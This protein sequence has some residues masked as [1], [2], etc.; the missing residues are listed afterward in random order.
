M[1]G[2]GNIDLDI[3]YTYYLNKILPDYEYDPQLIVYNNLQGYGITRGASLSLSHSFNFPLRIR[4]GGTYLNTY[5]KVEDENGYMSK[6]MQVFTPVF[7]GTF[8][9]SYEFKKIGLKLNYTGKVMGPQLLPVYPEPFT[10]PEKSPWFTLQNFQITKSFKHGI[11]LYSGIRNIFNFTQPSPLIDPGDPF[12]D[13]FDT[14]YA[15][16]PLQVRRFYLG[17]RWNLKRKSIP[18]GFQMNINTDK[19][20]N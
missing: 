19:M 2:C 17:I 15:Y 16:G 8:G 3:F 9:I 10:R 5:Q 12:G 18:K 13:N 20:N 6:E 7:S 1:A 14:S 11:E 4:L